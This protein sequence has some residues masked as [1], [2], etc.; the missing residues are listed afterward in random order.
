MTFVVT[1]GTGSLGRHVVAALPGAK[2][3]S[4][5]TGTDLLRGTGLSALR[6]DV[7]VHCATSFRREVDMA[8]AV[9]SAR[10]AHLVYIS[11]VGC[12]RVPLPYYKQKHAAER[13]IAG[14]GV[15]HTILRA[16]QFHSLLRR[17]FDSTSK[18]PLM[19]VPGFAFQP[20]DEAEVGVELASLAQ[21]APSGIAPEMGG[22]EIREAVDFARM[23]LAAT[24]KKRTLVPLKVP[25]AT[26]RAYR[27]G[28]NLTPGRAVGERTFADYLSG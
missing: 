14:S 22:P 12:D 27:A 5:S 24:G 23:Y 1:G 25:G 21:A 9:L 2:A 15:P 26:Y 4:R 6:A 13:L 17:M 3:V 16:T 10:P 19:L 7:V 20:V 18:L 8:R 28:G 11:I